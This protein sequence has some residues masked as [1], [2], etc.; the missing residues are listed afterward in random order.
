MGQLLESVEDLRRKASDW[1]LH[2]HELTGPAHLYLQRGALPAGE[3]TTAGRAATQRVNCTRAD[4]VKKER[5]AG[6]VNGG[7]LSGCFILGNAGEL[8]FAIFSN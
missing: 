6:I 7:M 5:E 4:D 1:R 3:A 8:E 2:G